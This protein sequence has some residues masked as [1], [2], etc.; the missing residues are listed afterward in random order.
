MVSDLP[1]WH[2][3]N[4]LRV[5]CLCDVIAIVYMWCLAKFVV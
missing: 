5:P 2:V 4:M 3:S 1:A